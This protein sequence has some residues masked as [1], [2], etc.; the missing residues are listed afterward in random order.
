M[1]RN[2][3]WRAYYQGEAPEPITELI[4]E[5][6]IHEGNRD[7]LDRILY[8]RMGGLAQIY[9]I[10][11]D[12]NGDPGDFGDP[13]TATSLNLV[14]HGHTYPED[15]VYLVRVC[16]VQEESR[17]VQCSVYSQD[18]PPLPGFPSS[19]PWTG[20]IRYR[21]PHLETMYN[22]FK[23][24]TSGD[25]P[26]SEGTGITH[27]DEP[28]DIP[29][30]IVNWEA[31]FEGWS[32]LVD[33][34][35]AG[36]LPSVLLVDATEI[37]AM[38]KNW[39]RFNQVLDVDFFNS[40]ATVGLGT[41][42]MYQVFMNW[43]AFNQP[44]PSGF[45]ANVNEIQNFDETF[46]GWISFNNIISQNFMSRL[47]AATNMHYTFRAWQSFN[48]T[49]PE[50]F[51][52]SMP[53]CTNFIG[54]FQ[55]W[56][57]FNQPLTFNNFMSNTQSAQTMQACFY[58]WESFNSEL[59]ANF[60][61]SDMQNCTTMELAFGQWADY[62]RRFP[63]ATMT[64]YLRT[65]RTWR[66]CYAGM[67]AYAGPRLPVSVTGQAQAPSMYECYN[68]N[69]LMTGTGM[70]VVGARSDWTAVS[71]TNVTRCFGGCTSLSD[72]ASIPASWK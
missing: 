43:Y 19:H 38:F 65:V 2:I 55:L 10:N 68:G 16:T 8:I 71:G 35:C 7:L 30:T 66:Q 67:V 22:A 69:S 27:V 1:A 57:E 51:C 26:D 23:R 60:M 13:Y 42:G 5:L 52:S 64:G 54:T 18:L 6:T 28:F 44:L 49:M 15:G 33:G 50:Q 31:A 17:L 25:L 56:T 70:N 63:T 14:G 59:N 3:H 41:R 36:W 45:C 72:Y 61:S 37:A 62:N 46:G 39:Q 11:W 4:L 20:I 47:N 12:W 24:G 32:H 48:Q 34:L 53:N 58:G 40:N 9:Y 29:S 21:A